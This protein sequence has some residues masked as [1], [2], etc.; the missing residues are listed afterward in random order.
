MERD[1][2]RDERQRVLL[3]WHQ[4]PR[5]DNAPKPTDES[6]DNNDYICSVLGQGIGVVTAVGGGGKES[7]KGNWAG[8]P[9]VS[10]ASM[11]MTGPQTD[12]TLNNDRSLQNPIDPAD[13]K[14]IA[15]AAPQP[16]AAP[17]Q[18]VAP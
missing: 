16:E 15:T 9:N 3:K 13:W 4:W 12:Q 14:R 8:F 11:P 5:A 6:R 1:K 2:Q 7:L 18:Q 17:V 10:I